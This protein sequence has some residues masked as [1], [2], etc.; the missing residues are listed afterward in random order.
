MY[1]LAEKTAVL[2]APDVEF[3]FMHK[4]IGLKLA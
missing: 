4:N 2:P 1:S 3:I